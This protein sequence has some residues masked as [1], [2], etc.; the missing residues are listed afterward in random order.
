MLSFAIPVKFRDGDV[1]FTTG[2][3]DRGLA[4]LVGVLGRG[5]VV[6]FPEASDLRGDPFLRGERP[7]AFRVEGC[8]IVV[9]SE[10]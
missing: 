10:R 1:L 9:V 6:A 7:K 2:V 4:F 8:I 3:D 5:G